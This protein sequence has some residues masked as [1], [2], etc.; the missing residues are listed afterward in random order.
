MK[1]VNNTDQQV[2][3][4]SNTDVMVQNSCLFFVF[5][6][7]AFHRSSWARFARA[8]V[9]LAALTFSRVRGRSFLAGRS[10]M[11]SWRF[12]LL[13]S[14]SRRLSNCESGPVCQWRC[15]HLFCFDCPSIS[16][17]ILIVKQIF[18]F[19]LGEGSGDV[20]GDNGLCPF[21]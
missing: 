11:S 21:P 19:C 10:D 13:G 14:F 20:T 5:C 6:F 2:Y 16:I 9:A 7:S 17:L 15:L 12:L 1:A 18:V 8:S 3:R 4:Y